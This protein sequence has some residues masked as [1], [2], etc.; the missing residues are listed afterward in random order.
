M[1]AEK[2]RCAERGVVAIYENLVRAEGVE[3]IE[4][5]DERLFLENTSNTVV[6]LEILEVLRRI[7]SQIGLR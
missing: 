6:L 3:S 4:Q 2:K 5:L 1:E 7:E